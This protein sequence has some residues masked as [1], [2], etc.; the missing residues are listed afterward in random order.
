[1]ATGRNEMKIRLQLLVKSDIGEIV[2]TEEVAQFERNSL[3]TEEVG[4]SLA[5]AKQMLGNMQRALVQEQV[6]ECIDEQSRCSH[7]GRTLSRKGQHGI[8]FRTLF[9]DLR[10]TSPRFYSCRCQAA[11][12]TSFSPLARLLPERTAPELIYLETKFAAL[13]SYGLTVSI[14]SEILPVGD[15]LNTRSLRRQIARTA[16]RMES[17][18][19]EEQWAFIEGCQRD[20]NRLPRPGP[21]LMVGLDGGFVHAKGQPSR[22][23]GWFE[24]IVGKSIA[25]E[26]ESKCLAFVQ[27]YDQKPKRRLFELLKSQQMQM[28]Q[29]ITFLTDGGED[30]RDL[31][32]FINPEAEHI[33]DWFHITKRLT[34]MSQVA[35]GLYGVSRSS[36]DD[37]DTEILDSTRIEK[38]LKRLKWYLWHGNVYQAL[39][40]IEFLEWDLEEWED[41]SEAAAKLLTA[42]QEFGHY[43]SINR[44]AIPNYGDH[45]RHGEVISTAFVESAVNQIVSRRMVKLQQMRWTKAGAHLLLQIRTHVLNDEL[46]SRFQ[47]WYP[48]MKAA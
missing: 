3:Q 22:A 34:V 48:A 39:K 8:V 18:L 37:V 33:L 45:Y 29:Q 30:I 9:G 40:R 16:E 27:T 20:W 4:L 26:G 13:M 46:R 1:M 5:E 28:N 19:G 35:K 2:N 31:P 38:S 15:Q 44:N 7:W 47:N 10:L 32:Q 25:S 14:L 12:R 11:A 6:A 21:P 42:V 41:H 23:E 17:E 43:I 24:V 36:E